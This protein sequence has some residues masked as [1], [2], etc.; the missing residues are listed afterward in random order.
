M[1]FAPFKPYA[2][3]GAVLAAACAGLVASDRINTD[4][5]V[6]LLPTIFLLGGCFA[7]IHAIVVGIAAYRGK[8]SRKTGEPVRFSDGVNLMLFAS[9]LIGAMAVIGSHP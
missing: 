3:A 9:I 8:R 7:F 5:L 4:D 1:S 6:L 2:I